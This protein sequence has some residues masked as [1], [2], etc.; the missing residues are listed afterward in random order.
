MVNHDGLVLIHKY[1]PLDHQNIVETVSV[2][3]Q[4]MSRV[5]TRWLEQV[6]ALGHIT[7]VDGI[8]YYPVAIVYSPESL[9]GRPVEIAKV[10]EPVQAPTGRKILI[11]GGKDNGE[12]VK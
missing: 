2:H 7:M 1:P 3:A 9:T 4:S 11:K 6:E 5:K 12:K 8:A 10:P